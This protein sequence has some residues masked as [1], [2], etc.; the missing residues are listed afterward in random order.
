MLK[1][2]WFVVVM[3]SLILRDFTTIQHESVS[4]SNG[5]GLNI[6]QERA[7]TV[8]AVLNTSSI[9]GEGTELTLTWKIPTHMPDG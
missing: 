5:F 2:R 6:R 1:M 9:P 7:H 4:I 8:G 3:N